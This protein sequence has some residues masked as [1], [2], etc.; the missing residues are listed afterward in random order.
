MTEDAA[1]NREA[2]RPAAPTSE[3]RVARRGF[4]TAAG[5][6]LG[7]AAISGNFLPL[8]PGTSDEAAPPPATP[9]DGDGGLSIFIVEDYLE[10]DS[11]DRAWQRAIDAALSTDLPAKVVLGTRSRYR[12][13]ASV[14]IGAGNGL[15]VA[16][17]GP[18]ATIIEAAPGAGRL[19]TAFEVPP[20]V[21]GEVRG[22][23]IRDLGF[24]GGISN[25]D[26]LVDDDGVP[27]ISRSEREFAAD[28]L[29]TA[30]FIQGDRAP[31]DGTAAQFA[32][33]VDVEISHVRVYGTRGLPLLI[34]GVNGTAVVQD[35]TFAWCMDIGFTFCESVVF[36]RN[37]VRWSADNGVSISR[38]T[39]NVTCTGNNI[40]G[41]YASGIWLGGFQRTGSADGPAISAAPGA[42]NALVS[43]NSIT[44]SGANGIWLGDGPQRVTVTGNQVVGVSRRAPDPAKTRTAA[45]DEQDLAHGNGLYVDEMAGLDDSSV[46][47]DIT[48]SGNTFSDCANGGVLIHAG[49]AGA[50]I[51][52]NTILRPG[53]DRGPSGAFVTG[54]AGR[55]NFGIAVPGTSAA[56]LGSGVS[57]VI[58]HSNVVIDDRAPRREVGGVASPTLE[59]GVY[60]NPHVKDAVLGENIVYGARR[61]MT[62]NE[63]PVV[64]PLPEDG[65]PPAASVAVGATYFDSRRQRLLV[66]DGRRWLTTALSD[67]D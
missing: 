38:G 46:A 42:D 14:R 49:V 53:R 61:P 47:R 3:P 16:G 4:L 51:S 50:Y 44:M 31:Q 32:S 63:P 20:G 40:E 10:D 1:E 6:I 65:A 33:V 22:L 57:R 56:E 58:V 67:A 19:G 26:A 36:S 28:N 23:V 64:T 43:S 55:A 5:V 12:F 2:D 54:A 37:V 62:R 11:D 15:V 39:Q 41:S 13:A 7:G 21:G 35:S 17:L 24:D 18:R 27:R 30:V 8:P 34:S 66:S 29:A 60:M 52:G 45:E 59:Y 9:A 25:A 48:V